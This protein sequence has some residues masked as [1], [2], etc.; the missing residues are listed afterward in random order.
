[1][2]YKERLL[3]I[4]GKLWHGWKK[5]NANRVTMPGNIFTEI[6]KAK[7]DE[8][9]CDSD[10]YLNLA[11]CKYQI[12]HVTVEVNRRRTLCRLPDTGEVQSYFS[13]AHLAAIYFYKVYLQ[14]KHKD[15]KTPHDILLMV[16]LE[17]KYSRFISNPWRTHY[18]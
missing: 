1:M 9:I 17:P 13:G 2:K 11:G 4:L 14:L 10:Y 6:L 7:G 12:E 3:E 18:V 16:I 15:D 5:T 8:I